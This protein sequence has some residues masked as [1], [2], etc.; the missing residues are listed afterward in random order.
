MYPKAQI[1]LTGH[2]LG[3]ALA[4]LLG[5]TF[6]VPTVAFE[7]PGD[8]MAA[9]RLHLPLPPGNGGE[10]ITHVYHTAGELLAVLSAPPSLD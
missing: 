9:R 6:G 8:V 3:G 4:A 7:S 1:W 5:V 2:S 10:T